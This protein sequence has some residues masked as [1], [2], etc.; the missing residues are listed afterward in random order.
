M[1]VEI[2]EADG[3][4]SFSY[5]ESGIRFQIIEVIYREDNHMY[6]RASSTKYK[7]VKAKGRTKSKN[8]W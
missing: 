4:L 7:D 1:K 3:Q 2:I 6:I 8:K 5:Q